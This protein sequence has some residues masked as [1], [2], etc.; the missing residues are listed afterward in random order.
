[1]PW[2]YEGEYSIVGGVHLQKRWLRPENSETLTTLLL[3]R[4]IGILPVQWRSYTSAT[5][6]EAVRLFLDP[7]VNIAWPIAI[8]GFYD[9]LHHLEDR[10]IPHNWRIDKEILCTAFKRPDVTA[11]M[12]DCLFPIVAE[13]NGPTYMK[14]YYQQAIADAA[15]N[16]R[17]LVVIKW[18]V[19]RG[20]VPSNNQ[21]KNLFGISSLP[22]REIGRLYF[23]FC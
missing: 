10:E 3:D 22:W 1:M 15:F 21:L 11:D 6:E 5:L 19:G 9:E 13:D 7:A 23:H 20:F 17:K 4:K 12:L 16:S 18:A 8:R 14:E 2:K